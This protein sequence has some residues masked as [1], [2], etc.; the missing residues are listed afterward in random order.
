MT[1]VTAPAPRPAAADLTAARFLAN[2][3]AGR[4]EDTAV[5][6]L[7]D[8]IRALV[9]DLDATRL[10]LD[11][12]HKRIDALTMPDPGLTRM[13][14]DLER[15]AANWQERAEDAEAERDAALAALPD[16]RV[17]NS[18]AAVLEVDGKGYTA[19]ILRGW[20]N[21]IDDAYTAPAPV[22][23]A[24]VRAAEAAADADPVIVPDVPRFLLARAARAAGVL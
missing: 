9:A 22:P 11:A 14:E 1:P 6:E 18:I 3:E 19:G 16:A 10:L 12:A 23:A 20:A 8:T 2:F 13:F 17:I 4:T 15:D 5:L 21:R 7:A 24:D